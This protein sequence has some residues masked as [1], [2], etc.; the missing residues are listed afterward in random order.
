[1]SSTRQKQQPLVLWQGY[2]C[3]DGI[4]LS[5]HDQLQL[6]RLL[7]CRFSTVN[8]EHI[9]Q[10]NVQSIRSSRK[11]RLLFSNVTVNNKLI[12]KVE[13]ILEN[14]EYKAYLREYTAEQTATNPNFEKL[15]ITT[16]D[17]IDQIDIKNEK[18]QITI[19]YDKE[20][21][22]S[23]YHN[24]VFALNHDQIEAADPVILPALIDGI[25]GSGKTLTLFSMLRKMIE[26]LIDENINIQRNIL[27][28]TSKPGLN[29]VLQA[30]WL[31]EDNPLSRTQPGQK[32]IFLSEDEVYQQFSPL[33]D[34]NAPLSTPDFLALIKSTMLLREFKNQLA[35]TTTL[36]D[37]SLLQEFEMMAWAGDVETYLQLGE[38]ESFLSTAALK[39]ERAALWACYKLIITKLEASKQYTP[40]IST[41]DAKPTFYAV[42]HDEAQTG[43]LNIKLMLRLMARD[44]R[45]L[46]CAHSAQTTDKNIS[47]IP[48]F[49]S[50]LGVN[51][52]P[53]VVHPLTKSYR[54]PKLVSDFAGFVNQLRRYAAGGAIDKTEKQNAVATTLASTARGTLAFI[55]TSQLE[56]H[57]ALTPAN[58]TNTIIIT[59]PQDIDEAVARFGTGYV[60]TPSGFGGQEKPYVYLYNFLKSKSAAAASVALEKFESN[61]KDNINLPKSRQANNTLNPFFA[62]IYTAVTRAEHSFFLVEDD[63]PAAVHAHKHLLRHLTETIAALNES[64]PVTVAEVQTTPTQSES[65][66][67]HWLTVISD[68]IKDEKI[69]VAKRIWVTNLKNDI[70]DFDSTYLN[71][72]SA[73]KTPEKKPQK[74]PTSRKKGPA[75]A[76]AKAKAKS[77]TPARQSTQPAYPAEIREIIDENP[78]TLATRLTDP[79]YIEGVIKNVDYNQIINVDGQHISYLAYIVT[80]FRDKRLSEEERVILKSIFQMFEGKFPPTMQ[81]LTVSLTDELP[82]LH[83]LAYMLNDEFSAYFNKN[84]SLLHPLTAAYW[85]KPFFV[86]GRPENPSFSLFNIV[87]YFYC[88]NGLPLFLLSSLSHNKY[89]LLTT[90]NYLD[91][92]RYSFVHREHNKSYTILELLLLSPKNISIVKILL[93]KNITI[94]KTKSEWLFDIITRLGLN[95]PEKQQLRLGLNINTYVDATIQLALNDRKSIAELGRPT[96][97]G[98]THL[99]A[100]LT[101]TVFCDRLYENY[102][103]ATMGIKSLLLAAKIENLFSTR[104]F[105]KMIT[106]AQ[107]KV[108]L[109]FHVFNNPYLR[110]IIVELT[111][112]TALTANN[113]LFHTLS[114]NSL[115]NPYPSTYSL[116]NGKRVSA[117]DLMI[118]HKCLDTLL[119]ISQLH[120]TTFFRHAPPN[121]ILEPYNHMSI[122]CIGHLYTASRIAVFHDN[123]SNDID[124]RAYASH[125]MTFLFRTMRINSFGSQPTILTY[126]LEYFLDEFIT[127]FKFLKEYQ[128]PVEAE[129][130]AFLNQHLTID[131]N[132][133]HYIW[134]PLS[135]LVSSADGRMLLTRL[136]DLFPQLFNLIKDHQWSHPRHPDMLLRVLYES[137]IRD[138]FF[139]K[140]PHLLARAEAA[141]PVLMPISN[142]A[143]LTERIQPYHLPSFAKTRDTKLNQKDTIRLCAGDLHS[144]EKVVKYDNFLTLLF[145]IIKLESH[146]DITILYLANDIQVKARI[147][148]IFKDNPALVLAIFQHPILNL[149]LRVLNDNVSC[150]ELFYQNENGLDILISMIESHPEVILHLKQQITID[151]LLNKPVIP[152]PTRTRHEQHLTEILN[153]NPNF[154]VI[155]CKHMPALLLNINLQY[156]ITTQHSQIKTSVMSI[157][158]NDLDL[159]PIMVDLFILHSLSLYKRLSAETALKAY[160]TI[161]KTNGV[162]YSATDL[163]ISEKLDLELASEFM[164]QLKQNLGAQRIPLQFYAEINSA[165]PYIRNANQ[166]YFFCL[167]PIHLN[168]V[169]CTVKYLESK[170]YATFAAALCHRPQIRNDLAY[171]RSALAALIEDE[172]MGQPSLASMLR[173]HPGLVD[174]IPL[175]AW[176]SVAEENHYELLDIIRLNPLLSELYQLII[177]KHPSLK[178]VHL[179]AQQAKPSQQGLFASSTIEPISS[180]LTCQTPTPQ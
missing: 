94:D 98:V 66:P 81:T 115:F 31:A 22:L 11:R 60:D 61:H 132:P 87:A 165:S 162:Q 156:W 145:Q 47:P 169:M 96:Q 71:T 168:E 44:A 55:P 100:W 84:A 127:M 48:R 171:P 105:N 4:E 178:A 54:N 9:R 128:Q 123:F 51:G 90:L 79:A 8:Y 88:G 174:E 117:Y 148:Q 112:I 78:V 152:H 103:D 179:A 176:S 172:K 125:L 140:H 159:R 53:L 116:G 62:Q 111:K 154:L 76:K 166:L 113:H 35:H 118:E 167:Y 28:V 163:L 138:T 75:P 38:F 133:S 86:P 180:E 23:R 122:T 43:Y 150:F 1:M 34:V 3:A 52:E 33:A 58:N 72:V 170:D 130:A 177:E 36:D 144:F 12:L 134:S 40:Y 175:T 146:D 104:D 2:C 106:T 42:F 45:Y 21:F 73:E 158:A 26:N 10:M 101:S 139:K 110:Y 142:P 107:G 131:S 57:L 70:K 19:P 15:D 27:V 46:L 147:M 155:L 59:N 18:Q 17:D 83:S 119:S 49:K 32:V 124:R 97:S 24:N 149:H 6:F 29:R 80:Y 41:W 92:I 114:M 74:K 160:F 157:L 153:Y 39:A 95:N 135:I 173:S 20:Y 37:A 109:L 93:K 16:F 141:E 151:M 89:Q 69:E 164:N 7:Q 108:P 13:R 56:A 5:D 64:T 91:L 85:Q 65:T 14:H 68:L 143:V 102:R 50:R 77:K 67:D 126:V 120:Q 136:F 121:F 99:E 30:E 137:N 25:A 129:L 82:L 63:A 161:P